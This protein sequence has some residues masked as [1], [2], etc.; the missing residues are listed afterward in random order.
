MTDPFQITVCKS[1]L[2]V[3]YIFKT[4]DTYAFMAYFMAWIVLTKLQL[5]AMIHST[6][7]TRTVC[8]LYFMG[9]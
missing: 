7:V 1:K 9:D 8:S 5:T 4:Y 6:H 2:T 3:R